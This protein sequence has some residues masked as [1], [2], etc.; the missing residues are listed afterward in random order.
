MDENQTALFE[1]QGHGL[2]ELTG[3]DAQSFLQNLC[4]Q[5]LRNLPV[6][7]SAEAFLTTNK[8][9]VVA[10]IWISRRE[11]NVY[12]LD[13]VAGQAEKVVAHLGHYLISEQVEIADRS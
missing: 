8:A 6:G 12:W 13:M 11:A 3:R 9:R 10:H 2:V 1:L 5:D 7:Q 4:T